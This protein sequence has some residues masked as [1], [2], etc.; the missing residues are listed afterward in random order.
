[1]D[2]KKKLQSLLRKNIQ[3]IAKKCGLRATHATAMLIDMI[4][5][6]SSS[7]EAAAKQIEMLIESSSDQD[8]AEGEYGKNDKVE[9]LING[10]WVCATVVR[11]NKKSLRLLTEQDES[12]TADFKAIRRILLVEST[13]ANSV[14]DDNTIAPSQVPM[15]EGETPEAQRE[16]RKVMRYP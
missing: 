15:E 4:S 6:L 8:A 13:A 16:A 5:E 12:I 7:N 1:M 14:D 10:A 2:V 9:T 3:F 11:V